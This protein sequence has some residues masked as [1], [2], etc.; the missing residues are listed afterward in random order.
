MI[1]RSEKAA[2]FIVI[3]RRKPQTRI[4]II[5]RAC[6]LMMYICWRSDKVG[7]FRMSFRDDHEVF[8]ECKRIQIISDSQ[9]A[10]RALRAVE[11]HSKAVKNCMDSLIQLVEHNMITLKWVRGHQGHEGNERADLSVKKGVEVPLIG[12]DRFQDRFHCR[13]DHTTLSTHATFNHNWGE[14]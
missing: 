4:S 6:T 7:N 12:P 1:E 3:R 11:I 10:L 14:N 8:T 13:T 5:S 2:S 9:A